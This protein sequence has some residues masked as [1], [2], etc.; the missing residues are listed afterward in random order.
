MEQERL[1]LPEHLISHR[2]LSEVCVHYYL[3]SCV[4]FCRPFFVLFDPFLLTIIV[5]VLRIM[6]SDY[7]IG[8]FF[9]M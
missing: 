5:S 4:V 2:I 8:I 6:A 3:V 9:T 1:A 7:P